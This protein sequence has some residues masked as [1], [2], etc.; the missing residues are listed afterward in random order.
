MPHVSVLDTC[1]AAALKPLCHL[2]KILDP[3]SDTLKR[4]SMQITL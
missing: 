3:T 2:A 1:I 4:M